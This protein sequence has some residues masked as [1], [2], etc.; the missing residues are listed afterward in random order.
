MP[1][2]TLPTSAELLSDVMCENCDEVA[3]TVRSNMGVTG[4][5]IFWIC[6]TCEA[7]CGECGV[8]FGHAKDCAQHPDQIADAALW[9]RQRE[10]EQREFERMPFCGSWAFENRIQRSFA[11]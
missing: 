5:T 10:A 6:A 2:E 8:A 1:I 3:G 7:T 4:G 9:E 11:R